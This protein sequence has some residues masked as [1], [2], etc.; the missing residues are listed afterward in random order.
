MKFVVYAPPYR[1]DSGGVIALHKLAHNLAELGEE[2]Y[3]YASVTNPVYKGIPTQSE[4]DA[5]GGVVI[6]PEIVKGNPLQAKKV[7]RWLLN[8]PG[9]L[10]GDGQ[11]GET[12]LIYKY[13]DIFDSPRPH[14]GILRA[15]ELNIDKYVDKGMHRSGSCYTIRKGTN[16]NVHP[17]D[18]ICFDHTISEKSLIHLFNTKETF[19]CYDELSFLLHQAAMCGCDAVAI[20]TIMNKSEEEWR[21]KTEFKYGVAYGVDD[22]GWTKSTK[23]LV[24]GFLMKEEIESIELTKQFIQDC[25]EESNNLWR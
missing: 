14:K 2:S 19:Y 3:I 24:K 8:S 10:G 25:H 5:A 12:D 6:Y 20:P 16:L 13:V 23:N 18:A 1:A 21:L 17:K 9:A 22:I 7:V 4:W 15:M 11:F